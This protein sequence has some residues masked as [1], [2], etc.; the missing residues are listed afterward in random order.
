MSTPP[1]RFVMK[2]QELP[3][4][5]IPLVMEAHKFARQFA[6]EQ[7]TPEKSKQ[8]YLNTLSVYAVHRYLQWLAID[9]HLNHGDSWNSVARSRLNVA[10]LVIPGKGKL[11]CRPVLPGETTFAI[12]KE[13][14]ENRIAY[15]AV[16]FRELLDKVE[17]LGFY[18]T[19]ADKIVH[20]NE[21][22]SLEELID[23]LSQPNIVALSQWLQGIFDNAWQAVEEVLG[24]L[25][26]NSFD[27]F[28]QASVSDSLASSIERYKLIDIGVTQVLLLV[29]ITPDTEQTVDVLVQIRPDKN[30]DYLPANLTLAFLSHTGVSIY[31]D[32]ST[33]HSTS[34]KIPRFTSNIGNIFSI[35]ISWDDLIIQENFII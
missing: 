32:K 17:L 19:A 3:I 24:T 18:S 4:I 20:L 27:S 7:T 26:V 15:I 14:A 12:S 31:Q 25:P 8:V 21:L 1:S 5:E 35:Q 29:S 16:Q 2:T 9:T 6:R 11:E 13:V 33:E 22:R 10:D 30:Q 34:L 28:Q 23:E